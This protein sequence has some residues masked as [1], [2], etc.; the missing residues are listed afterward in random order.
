MQKCPNPQPPIHHT[1]LDP[2]CPVRR[3]ETAIIEIKINNRMSHWQAKQEFQRIKGLA[4]SNGTIYAEIAATKHK[5]TPE[6]TNLMEIRRHKAEALEALAQL[7]KEIEELETIREEILEAER[8]KN[9]LLKIIS[10]HSNQNYS[11]DS[12][13]KFPQGMDM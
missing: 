8:K 6:M 10:R 3:R 7:K 4:S 5:E 13:E 2:D 11:E 1:S 12:T 9:Q